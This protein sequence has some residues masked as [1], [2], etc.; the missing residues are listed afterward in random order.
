MYNKEI[1][2]SLDKDNG[3]LYFCDANHPL[4]GSNGIVRYHRHVASL[5]ID[6]WLT[7]FEAVHHIDG[8]I[9]NNN[10]INLAIMTVTTHIKLHKPISIF[11]VLICPI[12]NKTFVSVY[13]GAKFCSQRCNN[14]NQKR[15][16][17]TKV[18]LE[19]LVWELPS[20]QI[21]KSFG[22]S[23]S[24]IVKRCKRLGI[25]KPPRGYWSK[26]YAGMV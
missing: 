14:Q 18:E 26:V 10:P 12:C 22:V 25:S 5:K 23:D 7:S 3:Y 1:K 20:S 4:A 19:K 17:I 9:L 6:R 15:F 24:T 11:E 21:A 2:L 13:K 8:N 16:E